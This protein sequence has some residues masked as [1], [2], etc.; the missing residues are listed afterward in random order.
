MLFSR[1]LLSRHPGADVIYDIK[2]SRN[3]GRVIEQAGG[4]PQMWRTGHSLLKARMQEVG[5]LLA[6]EMS[7]HLFLREGWFGFDD[8][9]YAAARL[10]QVMAADTRGAAAIFDE[11]PD[12]INTPELHVAMAEGEPNRLVES[13]Q[14]QPEIFGSARLTTMDGVRADYED[15]WGLVRASNTTP[16]LVLRF[17]AETETALKRIEGI[18]RSAITRWSPEIELPF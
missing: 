5:A 10:L 3:L 2:C 11:L 4:K 18:F 1:D 13:L 16:T 14:G 17:E 6:G 9:F 15:G 8:A 12:M 7:G